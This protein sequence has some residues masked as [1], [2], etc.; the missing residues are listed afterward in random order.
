SP[1]A[2][3]PGFEGPEQPHGAKP[4][5]DPAT[6]GW[7]APFIMAA[8]NTKNVHRSNFLMGHPYGEDFVYDEMVMT[9]PGEAGEKAAMALASSDAMA[10]DDG[11]KPGEGPS[12]EE[13]ETGFYDILFIG[14]TADG[15]SFR[16]SVQGDKDPGYGSTSKMI[17]EAAL[18]LTDE[19]KA[20]PGGIYTPAA[21]F[22]ANGERSR[23][24]TPGSF[25]AAAM[26]A[27]RLAAVP[28]ENVPFMA[29]TRPFTRGAGA[30]VF[31]FTCS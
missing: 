19:A 25:A 24:R 29:R 3:T 23:S 4:M 5:E 2:L 18:C 22:E 31:D 1:F 27:F 7:V 26:V 16:A 13:R 10:G 15:Q 30:P 14:E 9:G 17:A 20:L 8:I 21:A 11:P 6:G 12:K 28:P